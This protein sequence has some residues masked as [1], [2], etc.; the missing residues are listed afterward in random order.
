M[1]TCPYYHHHERTGANGEKRL[2]P[3]CRH[4]HAPIPCFAAPLAGLAREL[5]CLG[6]VTLCPIAPSEQL[7]VS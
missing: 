5:R 2:I 7:D 1:D 4:K 6:R 3:C